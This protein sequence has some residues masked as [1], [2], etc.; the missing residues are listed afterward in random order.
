LRF[1]LPSALAEPNFARFLTGYTL[2]LTGSSMVPI[3]LSFTIYAQGGGAGAVSK[4][5]AAE[6]IPMV[7]LL[8]L[9]GAI[10]DRYPRRQVMVAADL[11]RLVSQSTLALL[12]LTHHSPLPVIMALMALIG[13]GNAFYA[14][15][16][17]G[18]IPQLVSPAGL[19]SANGVAAIAQS[20][21]G[22]AGPIIGGLLV[23][24]TGG[25]AAIALDAA[26]Y[27]ISAGLLASLRLGPGVAPSGAGVLTQLREGWSEF[28]SHTWLWAIVLQFSLVHLLVVGPLFVLGS[29][30]FAHVP[31]GALGWG[32]LMALQGAGAVTGGLLAIH[33]KSPRPVR[34]ACLWFLLYG[35]VPASLAAHLPYPIVAACFFLGGVALAVFG[36]FWDTTLQSEIPPARLSRVVA[37]DMFGSFCLLPLGYL[38]A[39]PLAAAFGRDGALWVGAVFTV[40]SIVAVLFIRDVQQLRRPHPARAA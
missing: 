24:F 23:A 7:L 4:V 40:V 9:G 14:P 29:L 19:Q 21:A 3:A 27:A 1:L 20:A 10:A 8:L 6:M 38:L 5:L 32:G 25:A 28:R 34:A 17:A 15:G 18:L 16:R 12:L 11:L 13:T 39:A 22:I 33:L 35:L 36:V 26:S 2:S 37:Y 30:G 31:D